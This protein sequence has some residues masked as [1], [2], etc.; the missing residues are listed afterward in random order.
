MVMEG[1]GLS[2]WPASRYSELLPRLYGA[3]TL[4]KLKE[5]LYGLR[6]DG[7]LARLAA[8]GREGGAEQQPAA[9]GSAPA[10]AVAAAASASAAETVPVVPQ[11]PGPPQHTAEDASSRRRGLLEGRVQLPRQARGAGIA[12]GAEWSLTHHLRPSSASSSPRPGAR[13]H[14]HCLRCRHTSASRRSRCRQLNHSS[15]Q[16]PRRR[17]RE[18]QG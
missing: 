14:P 6:Q 17:R 2:A 7:T 18:Q 3:A 1:L 8:A 10:A 13:Q 16:L 5:L 12:P 4:G 15:H 11:P 9:D